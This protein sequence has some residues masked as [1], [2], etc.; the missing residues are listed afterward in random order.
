MLN[1]SASQLIHIFLQ[2]QE[3][4]SQSAM[5]EGVLPIDARAQYVQLSKSRNRI[6]G[7]AVDGHGQE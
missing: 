6:R 4:V 5:R 1:T 3:F 2:T 7:P